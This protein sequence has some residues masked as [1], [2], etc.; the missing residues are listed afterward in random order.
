MKDLADYRSGGRGGEGMAAAEH[1]VEDDAEGEDVG[2]AV[3]GRTIKDLGR[4]ILG[5]TGNHAG[6]GENGGSLRHPGFV[7]SLLREAEVD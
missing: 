6:H 3:G 1:L 7:S 2:A 5:G 4:H